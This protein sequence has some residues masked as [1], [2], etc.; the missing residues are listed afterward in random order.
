M[1][2]SPHLACHMKS[3]ECLPALRALADPTRQKLVKLLLAEPRHV[4]ALAEAI[5]TPQYNISKHLRILREAGIVVA[6]RSGK[7]VICEVEPDFRAKLR[8][9]GWSLD[10]GCCSFRFE[11]K[12]RRQ[13]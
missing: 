8:E 5:G 3:D 1:V 6:E 12:K 13:A 10:L 11:E 9:G 2:T 4:N 7:E